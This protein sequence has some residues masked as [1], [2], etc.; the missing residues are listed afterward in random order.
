LTGKAAVSELD[1]HTHSVKQRF[2]A[3]AQTYNGY[4]NVH[5]A[6]G[7]KLLGL[8]DA[9]D[10]PST[11]LEVGCGT[12]QLTAQIVRRFPDAHIDAIDISEN[13]VREA[14]RRIGERVAW[15]VTD[16]RAYRS[17]QP[18]DL[19]ITASA[20]HWLPP[21]PDTIRRLARM[22]VP[23]GRLLLA[24]MLHGTLR[25][26]HAARRRIAPHK[27]PRGALPDAHEARLAL[28]ENGFHIRASEVEQVTMKYPT[29]RHFLTSIHEQGLTGG[30]VSRASAPLMRGEIYNLIDDYQRHYAT[31]SGG[32]TATFRLFFANATV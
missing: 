11:I 25:E 6:A 18:Y 28:L 9:P 26:L 16:G 22:L 2:S 3:A 10:A 7:T 15:H 14:R 27:V 5:G 4:P 31:S 32:V 13:M 17:A 21:L 19:I 30:D 23:G 24:M 1:A 20:L 8:F 29:A 12:G